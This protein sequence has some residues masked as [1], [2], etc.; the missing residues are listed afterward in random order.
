MGGVDFV[1]LCRATFF[2]TEYADVNEHSAARV[3]FRSRNIVVGVNGLR[4]EA[5]CENAGRDDQVTK[6]VQSNSLV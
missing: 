1:D 4:H 3:G 5:Q 2:T 6:A